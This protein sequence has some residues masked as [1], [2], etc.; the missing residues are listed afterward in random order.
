M[1]GV[2]HEDRYTFFIISRS[3]LLRMRKISDKICTG[4]Q[5]THFELS[6]FFFFLQ[7]PAV[8]GKCAKIF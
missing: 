1:S 8:V 3:L 7:N 2:L 4:N 6:N 5:N